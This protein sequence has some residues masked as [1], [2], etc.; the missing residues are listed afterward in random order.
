MRKDPK[1]GAGKR[2]IKDPKKMLGKTAKKPE[3]DD[4]PLK[5][6]ATQKR[7]K[8]RQKLEQAKL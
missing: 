4:R 8:L 3:D 5:H 7:H 6:N 1:R 2:A